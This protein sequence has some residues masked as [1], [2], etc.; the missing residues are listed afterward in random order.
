M[1]LVSTEK[2]LFM[3]QYEWNVRKSISSL[4][5]SWVLT[6]WPGILWETFPEVLFYPKAGMQTIQMNGHE[7]H[8]HNVRAH[9]H[10]VWSYLL[11]HRSFLQPPDM[12][13]EEKYTMSS[14][15][16]LLKYTRFDLDSCK[17]SKASQN[18]NSA[19]ASAQW[20]RLPGRRSGGA[21][22][23][24]TGKNDPDTESGSKLKKQILVFMPDRKTRWA[25]TVYLFAH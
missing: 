25:R 1:S 14:R 5:A 13:R 16:K 18:V 3:C 17:N 8:T 11:M 10:T 15:T 19:Q 7:R 23:S 4:L 6:S 20:L 24:F 12:K 21:A 9:T 22:S 2:V